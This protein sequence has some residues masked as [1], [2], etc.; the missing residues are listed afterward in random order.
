MSA[1]YLHHVDLKETVKTIVAFSGLNQS[2]N[3]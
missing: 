1:I 2:D 3:Y